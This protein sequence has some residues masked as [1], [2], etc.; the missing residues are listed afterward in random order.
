M[1]IFSAVIWTSDR[2]ASSVDH[3]VLWDS[4]R[5]VYSSSCWYMPPGSCPDPPHC[6]R[7]RCTRESHGTRSTFREER[8]TFRLSATTTS[9][10]VHHYQLIVLYTKQRPK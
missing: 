8:N 9:D 6:S 10:R 4:S 5:S 7:S 3:H 1:L 2:E